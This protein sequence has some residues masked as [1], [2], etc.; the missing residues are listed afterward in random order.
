MT[1][2]LEILG[3]GCEY[4]DTEPPPHEIQCSVGG[5]NCVSVLEMPCEATFDNYS[6]FD[7]DPCDG[8]GNG[9]AG[10]CYA[11]EYSESFLDGWLADIAG[12]DFICD[13]CR[14]AFSYCYECQHFDYDDNMI[15]SDAHGEMYCEDCYWEY[16]RDRDDFSIHPYSYKPDPIFHASDTD[17]QA[18][19]PFIRDFMAPQKPVIRDRIFLGVELETNETREIPNLAEFVN[20]DQED[21]VYLKK[22][23]SVDGPEI[24]THPMTLDYHKNEFEWEALIEEAECDGLYPDGAGLH[25]HASRASFGIDRLAQAQTETNILA[26]LELHWDQMV[27]LARRESSDW[28]RK[29][30]VDPIYRNEPLSETIDKLEYGKSAGRYTA[31]NFENEHTIEFRMFAATFETGIIFATLE[32]VTLLCELGREMTLAD[33]LATTFNDLLIEAQIRGYD[34]LV[35]YFSN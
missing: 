17:R 19:E 20:Q 28:A 4:Y 30:C 32:A 16:G 12:F 22:D 10:D 35:N 13:Y 5:W 31:I 8:W 26:L 15:F 7:C 6:C 27:T 9:Q 29:N 25:V 3:C 34:N 11:Y 18:E 14:D 2:Q 33:I 24:V 21:H 1:E 23:I